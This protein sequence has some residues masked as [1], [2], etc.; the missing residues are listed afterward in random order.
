MRIGRFG[1]WTYY[2]HLSVECADGGY[3]WGKVRFKVDARFKVN[4][5]GSFIQVLQ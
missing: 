2:I 4:A 3:F 1:V 5:L